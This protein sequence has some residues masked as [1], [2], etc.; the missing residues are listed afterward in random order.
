M[1]MQP[2]LFL[3]GEGGVKAEAVTA[4]ILVRSRDVCRDEVQFLEVRGRILP[5]FRFKVILEAQYIYYVL[6]LWTIHRKAL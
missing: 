6:L 2:P 1:R 4:L 3:C 5:I